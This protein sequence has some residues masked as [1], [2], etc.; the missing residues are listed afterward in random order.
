MKRTL[1]NEGY[2]IFSKYHLNDRVT[3]CD[4]TLCITNEYDEFLHKTPLLELTGAGLIIYV[5]SVN[6]MDEA[7]NDFKYFFPRMLEIICSEPP[8]ISDIDFSI[9][10]WNR[11]AE[12]N[13]E[14]WTEN[15]K[16]FVI[17]FFRNF[18]NETKEP[19]EPELINPS[20]EDIR[21]DVFQ[22]LSI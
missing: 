8:T 17:E 6:T 12:I 14:N 2:E 15:E 4:C 9:F 3:G 16:K 11:F 22:K 1:I 19:N 5:Q 20:I 21:R 18:W 13:F 7:S 10:V